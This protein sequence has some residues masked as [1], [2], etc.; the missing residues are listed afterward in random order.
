MIESVRWTFWD[1]VSPTGRNKL[2]EWA[3]KDLS[4]YGRFML[5]GILKDARKIRNPKDWACFR[6][7]LR[8]ADSK[9]ERI[10][11]LGFFADG[12][13]YRLL[14]RQTDGPQRLALLVGCY[15]KQKRYT[16]P[17]ALR[18]AVIRSRRLRNGE[19]SLHERPVRSDL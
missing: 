15:H 2:T 19:A 16:P 18:S 1:Y 6:E 10:F 14:C 9:Q 5:N 4:D 17:D 8:G 3:R 7:Y 11:E 12:R 13:Q